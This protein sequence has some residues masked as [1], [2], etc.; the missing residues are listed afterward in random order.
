[1]NKSNHNQTKEVKRS[2]VDDLYEHYESLFPEELAEPWDRPRIGKQFYKPHAKPSKVLYALDLTL[3]VVEEA[4]ALGVKFI[5]THHPFFFDPVQRIN[6]DSPRTKIIAK[7]IEHEIECFSMHTNLDARV[8][9]T[10][11]EMFGGKLIY[12]AEGN[13]FLKVVDIPKQSFQAVIDHTKHVFELDG[14]RYLGNLADSVTRVGIIGGA[15]CSEAVINEL[16][17]LDCDVFITSEIKLHHTLYAHGYHFKLIEV[18]HG[19]EAFVF[20]HNV[21]QWEGCDAIE[22]QDYFISKVDPDPMRFQ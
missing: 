1:M 4:I 6:L 13:S 9:D 20:K 2:T 11:A 19:I 21:K 16:V 18:S 14:V 5:V 17:A 8:G 3:E 7:M 10:L 15:G 12:G 22:G